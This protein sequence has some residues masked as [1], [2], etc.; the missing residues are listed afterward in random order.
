MAKALG[1]HINKRL[2]K[3]EG[4]FDKSIEKLNISKKFRV[5]QI[6]VEITLN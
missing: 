1:K 3:R 4:K 2:R 6:Q 5:I